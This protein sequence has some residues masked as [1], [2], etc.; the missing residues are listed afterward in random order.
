MGGTVSPQA[1]GWPSVIA[2]TSKGPLLICPLPERAHSCLPLVFNLSA[3]EG[4]VPE[5]DSLG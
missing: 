2:Q 4:A 5:Q 3:E 1:L